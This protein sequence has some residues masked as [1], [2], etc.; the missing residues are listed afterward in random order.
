MKKYDNMTLEELW[1]AAQ[2]AKAG[3][4]CRQIHRELKRS[5]KHDGLPMYR[6]YPNLPLVI[7]VVS[8]LLVLLQIFFTCI[9]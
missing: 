3:K 8:L 7:S 1:D 9:H 6:R 4:E 2:S 5:N